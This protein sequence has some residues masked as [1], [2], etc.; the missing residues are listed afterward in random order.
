MRHLLQFS[1]MVLLVFGAPSC[2]TQ[3][4]KPSE[5][6][7]NATE[8]ETA[9]TAKTVA[10]TAIKAEV[11][12]FHFTARC[13]TCLAI[14]EQAKKNVESLYPGKV[15]FQSINI[16]EASSK[17]LVKKMQVAGQ[18]LLL[19]SGGSR[20]DITREGFMYARSDPNMFRAILKEKLDSL[21][22]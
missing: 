17:E 9:V 18:A 6:A 10:D 13:V 8:S 12:Y 15:T 1:L 3:N 19:V 14:E 22:R 5:N 4:E 2:T 21:L 20:K 11:Y 16:D 7:Q